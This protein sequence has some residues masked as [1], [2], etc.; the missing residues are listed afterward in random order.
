MVNYVFFE[1]LLFA[2][3]FASPDTQK[4]AIEMVSEGKEVMVWHYDGK[5]L[6]VEMDGKSEEL[7]IRFLDNA[8][9]SVLQKGADPVTVDIAPYFTQLHNWQTRAKRAQNIIDTAEQPLHI[10]PGKHNI[11]IMSPSNGVTFV[12]SKSYF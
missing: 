12:I 4:I 7:E 9:Y 2:L 1:I 3:Y 11:Y 8:L 5:V 10:V 6:K